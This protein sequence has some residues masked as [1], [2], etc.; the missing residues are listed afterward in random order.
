MQYRSAA[1]AASARGEAR[2]KGRA[3]ACDT[4]PYTHGCRRQQPDERRRGGPDAVPR[5]Q[6]HSTGSRPTHGTTRPRI[7]PSSAPRPRPLQAPPSAPALHVAQQAAAVRRRATAGSTA[8]TRAGIGGRRRPRGG[9]CAGGDAPRIAASRARLH[10]PP[11]A[12]GAALGGVARRTRVCSRP[13]ARHAPRGMQRAGPCPGV[14]PPPHCIPAPP[15]TNTRRTRLLSVLPPSCFSL[16]QVARTR[17]GQE[18]C[19][20]QCSLGRA[21][22]P[23]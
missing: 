8:A 10:H 3:C 15:R 23:I 7:A 14:H 4:P 2:G 22:R 16:R 5:T 9:G 11:A 20:T 1:A 17:R 6:S 18:L 13:P 21:V 12:L 19:G